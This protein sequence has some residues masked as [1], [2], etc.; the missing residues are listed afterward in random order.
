MKCDDCLY[1]DWKRM[2]SGRPHP[3][4]VGRCLFEKA[5]PLPAATPSYRFGSTV[6][7]KF[8]VVIKG[9]IIERGAELTARCAYFGRAK[10]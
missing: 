7:E 2:V 10:Q 1:A 6:S 3:N 4:K 5:V 8:E 9:G